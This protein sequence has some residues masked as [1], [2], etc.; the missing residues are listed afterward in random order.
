MKRFTFVLILAALVLAACKPAGQTLPNPVTVTPWPATPTKPPL[1]TPTPL[2]TPTLAPTSVAQT[3]PVPAGPIDAQ[4]APGLRATRLSLPGP[5]WKLLWPQPGGLRVL[6]QADT[7]TSA[8]IF[9]FDLLALDEAPAAGVFDLPEN[10]LDVSPDGRVT[11]YVDAA[12]QMRLA[13]ADGSEVRLPVQG[14]VY[15]GT[16]SDDGA[17][18]VS[19]SAERWEASVW[20]A[21]SGKK[22]AVMDDFET[23]AP[24]YGA[25]AGYGSTLMWLARASVQ[26]DDVETGQTR[27]RLGY[28][29]FVSGWAFAPDGQSLGLA[30]EGKVRAVDLFSGV[31]RW[32]VDS[33]GVYALAYAPNSAVLA[34]AGSQG[35]YLWDAASGALLAHLEGSALEVRFS[36]DGSALAVRLDDGGVVVWR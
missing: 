29:D 36:P 24:V 32:A 13:V 1:R 8:A 9:D 35:V 34:G 21:A 7:P 17:R 10:Y 5:A 28:M 27:F 26:V 19:T 6:L 3:M 18:F 2:P 31:E 14:V 16:F 12:G 20:E 25:Y 11:A 22:L 23:A 30:V 4:S 33:Q 15:G